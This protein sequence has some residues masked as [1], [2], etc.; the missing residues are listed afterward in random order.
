MRRLWAVCLLAAVAC[1]DR[2]VPTVAVTGEIAVTGAG[3]GALGGHPIALFSAS[4]GTVHAATTDAM[5]RFTFARLAAGAYVVQTQLP[6]TAE[7]LRSAAVEVAA[8]ADVALPPLSFVG[9]GTIAGEVGEAGGGSLAGA[10]VLAGDRSTPVAAGSDGRFTIEAIPA[11]PQIVVAFAPGRRAAVSTSVDVTWQGRA[12]VG[13]IELTTVEGTQ[14]LSG[15]VSYPGPPGVVPPILV[16]VDD[17]KWQTTA[18]ATGAFGVPGVPDGVH[19]LDFYETTPATPGAP[20]PLHNRLPKVFVAS[21]QTLAMGTS[22]AP[23]P[24]IPLYRGRRIANAQSTITAASPD[25]R[26]L[27]ASVGYPA[28]SYL[29]GVDGTQVPLDGVCGFAA[30]GLVCEE[31]VSFMSQPSKLARLTFVPL[32]APHTP[33]ILHDRAL[34]FRKLPGGDRVLVAEPGTLA[35]KLAFRV[36]APGSTAVLLEGETGELYTM[37]L[38][39]SGARFAI[40]DQTKTTLFDTVTGQRLGEHAGGSPLFAGDRAFV[41]ALEGIVELGMP[42]GTP[43][44]TTAY[45]APIEASPNGQMII[46]SAAGWSGPQSGIVRVSDGKQ[47][48]DRFGTAHVTWSADGTKAWAMVDRFNTMSPGPGE[49][50][51]LDLQSG[52]V[53]TVLPTVQWGFSHPRHPTIWFCNDSTKELVIDAVSGAQLPLVDGNAWWTSVLA[54]YVPD[55]VVVYTRGYTSPYASGRIDWLALPALTLTPIA[56]RATLTTG[57]A[58]PLND[59]LVTDPAGRHVAFPID[60]GSALVVHDRATA[61]THWIGALASSQVSDLVFVEGGAVVSRRSVTSPGLSELA[62]LFVTEFAP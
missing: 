20:V 51:E 62:G 23:L 22:I 24:T 18:D 43:P 52:A 53:R 16:S 8:T 10:Q 6:E 17:G 29:I 1:D 61:Q 9:L 59:Q 31:R 35:G 39:K 48:L 12:D 54:R 37:A 47:L 57:Y 56:A 42:A 26:W 13:R 4:G 15:R 34:W 19:S 41:S 27:L 40:C 33:V 30:S 44:L 60:D 32:V 46:T 5:G 25:Q 11:G 3:P 50:I 2:P 28:A 45:A 14:L 36:V 7:G 58:L 49:L 38:A 55:G 21:G